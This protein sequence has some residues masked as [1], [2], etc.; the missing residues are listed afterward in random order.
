MSARTCTMGCA[1]SSSGWACWP[2]CFAD[3]S[4][5]RASRGARSWIGS[6]STSRA[7]T[8]HAR[9]LARGLSPLALE[10]EYGLLLALGELVDQTEQV[11]GLSCVFRCDELVE[12]QDASVANHLYHLAREAVVNA[13]K[14]AQG[15]TIHVELREEAGLLTLTIDDDGRGLPTHGPVPRGMGLRVLE[16]RARQLRARLVFDR[17]PLGGLRV[18][19]AVPWQRDEGESF[20]LYAPLLGA[21]V[22]LHQGVRYT[23]GRTREADLRFPSSRVSRRHAEFRWEDGRWTLVDLG[24]TN[25]TAVNGEPLVG[26]RTL[27]SGDRLSFGGCEAVL[28][29]GAAREDPAQL[30]EATQRL[31]PKAR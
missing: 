20:W 25:G 17:S 5:G 29:A 18:R 8:S 21:P 16:E 4:R 19:C 28:R 2:S 6:S 26:P 23:V 30:K 24:S 12:V 11:F 15:S 13:A 27:S 31:M 3:A 14:H 9:A 22:L 1:R 7:A 10:D